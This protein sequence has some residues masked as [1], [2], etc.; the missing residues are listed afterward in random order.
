MSIFGLISFTIS[1]I[2][3]SQNVSVYVSPHPDDWQLFMNP[4]AYHSIKITADKVIF[5]HI[6]A[7]DGG[8]GASPYSIARE[9]GSKRAIRFMANTFD[10]GVG[11]NMNPS[12]ALINGHLIQKYTYQ[13]II[14][15]FLKLPDGNTDGAG[16]NTHNFTSLQK[17]FNGTISSISAIDGS[18]TYNSLNDLETTIKALVESEL[19]SSGNIQFHIADTDFEINRG[20]HSDHI[21]SSRIMQEVA[22][23]IGGVTLY[24]YEDY[25]SDRKDENVTG[26][27]LLIDLGTWAVTTS[28]LSDNNA[29][30]TWNIGHNGWLGRQY[31][32]VVSS[33]SNN[34]PLARDDFESI[35]VDETL[36]GIVYGNDSGLGDIPISYSITSNVSNGELLFNTNGTYTYTPNFGY[37]GQ[38]NF[39][40]TVC[41][42]NGECSSASVSITIHSIN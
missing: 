35:N 10:A 40:Y 17:L 24:L 25:I 19:V 6:T 33:N 3:K 15:Y 37:I 12:I 7:G 41:D 16:Y 23:N 21:N 30:G 20:D 1:P 14:I 18:A 11:S 34:I 28:G 38:D 39:S 4:N 2:I 8:S 9:E 13:N 42:G 26:D 27:D 22:N 31:F 5:L 36:S 29:N 32:R